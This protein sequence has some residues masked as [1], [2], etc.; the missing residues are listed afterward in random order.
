MSKRDFGCIDSFVVQR[1]QELSKKRKNTA[2]I[3]PEADLEFGRAKE[4][5]P[6]VCIRC[7]QTKVRCCPYPNS[8]SCR[9]CFLKGLICVPAP[10][11]I[12]KR[13]LNSETQTQ[14]SS[15]QNAKNVIRQF[16]VGEQV[17]CGPCCIDEQNLP[18][19]ACPPYVLP[20]NGLAAAANDR[21]IPLQSLTLTG[22]E[23]E[24]NNFR[25]SYVLQTNG[26]TVFAS[27]C[28][29]SSSFNSP[30]GK[31]FIHWIDL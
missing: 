21:N 26:N 2:V 23:R 20:S 7:R 6:W 14:V 8:S 5:L 29:I 10:S 18:I 30:E 16:G 1:Q 13:I 3:Q 19:N 9:N 27:V 12:K 17:D 4:S 25:K 11:Y 28:S 15:T 24:D 31:D 22:V